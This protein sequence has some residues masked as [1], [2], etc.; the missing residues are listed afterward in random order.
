MAQAGDTWWAG[1]VEKEPKGLVKLL[2]GKG[3]R[4]TTLTCDK[5][6]LAANS[7]YFAAQIVR[8]MNSDLPEWIPLPD[9]DAIT[10]DFL[11][12]VLFSSF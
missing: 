7:P 9:E 1:P 4:Q 5:A 8:E 12:Q 2:V 10:L 3:S 6:T 11:L